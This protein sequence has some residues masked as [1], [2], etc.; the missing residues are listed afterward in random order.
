MFSEP[1][2]SFVTSGDID[3]LFSHLF[4]LAHCLVRNADGSF[5]KPVYIVINKRN[6]IMDI[7]NITGIL[8]TFESSYHDQETGIKLAIGG[9]DYLP[10]FHNITHTEQLLTLFDNTCF[11]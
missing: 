2:V 11:L 6:G 8:E 5:R 3:A 1:C 9:N 4:T 10:R 7:N